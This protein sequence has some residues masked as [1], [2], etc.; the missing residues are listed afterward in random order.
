MVS[1][2]DYVPISIYRKRNSLTIYILSIES[3]LL[4]RLAP[5]NSAITGN[6][7]DSKMLWTITEKESVVLN[8]AGGYDIV[9]SIYCNRI[10]YIIRLVIQLTSITSSKMLSV[11]YLNP[12]AVSVREIFSDGEVSKIIRLVYI[13]R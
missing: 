13:W 6:F 1:C 9:F 4:S 11:D 7:D 3:R 12:L 2:S 5:D 8:T 10:G